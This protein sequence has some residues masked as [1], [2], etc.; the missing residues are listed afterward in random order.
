MIYCLGA[1]YNFLLMILSITGDNKLINKIPIYII[2]FNPKV[3]ARMPTT[4]PTK[5]P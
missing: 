3:I 2:S 5:I 4:N 1:K